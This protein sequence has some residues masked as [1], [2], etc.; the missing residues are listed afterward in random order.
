MCGLVPLLGGLLADSEQIAEKIRYRVDNYTAAFPTILEI[1]SKEHPYGKKITVRGLI[2]R[3]GER[4]CTKTI[5]SI[6]R[7]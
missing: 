3:S 6:V 1:P 2:F 5:I 4:Q 7:K